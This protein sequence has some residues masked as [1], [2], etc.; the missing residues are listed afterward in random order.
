MGDNE[1]THNFESDVD[2][3]DDLSD[4]ELAKRLGLAAGVVGVGLSSDCSL[5]SGASAAV[6]ASLAVDGAVG[7]GATGSSSA[8]S[9]AAQLGEEAESDSSDEEDSDDSAEDGV[10]HEA[11]SAIGA[12]VATASRCRK[13]CDK[14]LLRSGILAVDLEGIRLG[15]NGEICIVQVATA[16]RDVYLFDVTALGHEAFT[17]GLKELL[18]SEAVTKLFFDCRGDCD[19]LYH[20]HQVKPVNV[21]DMQVLCHKAKAGDSKF[22]FGFAKALDQ[23]LPYQQRQ[24][25]KGIKEAG[26]SLFAPDRGGN[27]EVWKIRPLPE[28]LRTYCAC[29]VVH[30]F[31][32]LKTWEHCMPSTALR[33]VSETRMRKRI[34]NPVVET[35]PQLARMDFTFSLEPKIYRKTNVWVKPQGP[36]AGGSSSVQP[37]PFKRPRLGYASVA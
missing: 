23:V 19:A 8:A 11:R 30:L 17:S 16:E 4:A 26:H 20:L 7:G 27:L 13:V 25:M 18:E 37:P 24:V 12:V 21:L 9:T 29:D 34:G 28:V 10:D 22:L 33:E 5:A 6:V 35:G 1:T 15:R 3:A 14:L 31:V 2:S 36:N 32:M